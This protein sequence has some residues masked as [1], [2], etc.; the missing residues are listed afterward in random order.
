MRHHT[1]PSVD[2]LTGNQ[3]MLG[4][5]QSNLSWSAYLNTLPPIARRH[6]LNMPPNHSDVHIEITQSTNQPTN[7]KRSSLTSPGGYHSAPAPTATTAPTT[8]DTIV[9]SHSLSRPGGHNP[10][11]TPLSEAIQ[12]PV[13]VNPTGPPPSTMDPVQ[14]L[15]NDTAQD[16][17]LGPN[18]P[19]TEKNPQ[20]HHRIQIKLNLAPESQRT[21]HRHS[22][23]HLK[24]ANSPAPN[25]I[26]T[27]SRG[28]AKTAITTTAGKTS[29]HPQQLP[30][31]LSTP[32]L[33]LALT[34]HPPIKQTRRTSPRFNHRHRQAAPPSSYNR[35]HLA[36]PPLH[37][38]R[39]PPPYH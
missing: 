30:N 16:P 36:Q 25:S 5:L 35:I 13:T 29:T 1:D 28:T 24:N 2:T 38:N 17:T 3:R 12:T 19:E 32:P 18:G 39:T 6:Y 10:T 31:S 9:T 34:S 21:V 8:R 27:S 20:P 37:M 15:P 33:P 26:T 22:I 23:S 14:H 11:T 7:H 4:Y